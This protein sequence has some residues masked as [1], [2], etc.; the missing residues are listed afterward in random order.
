[1]LAVQPQVL[2]ILIAPG[3]VCRYGCGTKQIINYMAD[4][5]PSKYQQP[6]AWMDPDF[7]E[8]LFEPFTMNYTNSRTEF[9]FWSLWSAPLLVATDPADMSEEKKAILMN[10]EVLA[11]HQDSLFVGGERLWNRTS[12]EQLWQRPLSNGDIAVILWN[13]ASDAP[14][15][16]SVSWTELGWNDSD[17]VN[18]R[19]LWERQD[20]SPDEGI[21]AGWTGGYDSPLIPVHDHMMLRLTKLVPN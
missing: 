7:L 5:S 14:R 8:T 6:H 4:L 16:I 1:M 15:S 2:I 18:V 11:I 19:D 10:P 20:L 17:E 21:G 3:C 13:S 12:G 9:A